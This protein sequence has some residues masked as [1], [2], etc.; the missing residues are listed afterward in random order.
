[1]R[2]AQADITAADQ[3]NPDQVERSAREKLRERNLRR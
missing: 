1:M 3:E 2:G